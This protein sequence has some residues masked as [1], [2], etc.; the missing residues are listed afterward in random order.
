MK[1][2][3]RISQLI[4]NRAK[5]SD[6]YSEEIAYILS[7]MQDDIKES[8]LHVS[9]LDSLNSRQKAHKEIDKIINLITDDKSNYESDV[10]VLDK[11]EE[12]FFN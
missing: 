5:L 10:S 4:F 12:N 3:E 1:I 2:E 9:N 7:K 6:S 11:V 8:L